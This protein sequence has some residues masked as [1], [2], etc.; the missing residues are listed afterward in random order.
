MSLVKESCV[1]QEKAAGAL[2]AGIAN[3]G[4][5]AHYCTQLSPCLRRLQSRSHE[6]ACDHTMHAPMAV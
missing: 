3:M 5:A 6:K 4:K 1:K 2:S